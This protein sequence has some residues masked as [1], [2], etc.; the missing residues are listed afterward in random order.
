ML[1]INEYHAEIKWFPER[2]KPIVCT[3]IINARSMLNAE[4]TFH[5]CLYSAHFNY[6]EELKKLP[7]MMQNTV[8]RGITMYHME[9][10]KVRND[11]AC[12]VQ[13]C[14]GILRDNPFLLQ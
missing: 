1:L 6:G 10:D 2:K 9:E 7:L 11:L 3:Y 12:K 14:R 4:E 13:Y 5:N 8:A